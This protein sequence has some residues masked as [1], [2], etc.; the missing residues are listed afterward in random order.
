MHYIGTVGLSGS[1]GTDVVIDTESISGASVTKVLRITGDKAPNNY[2]IGDNIYL[3]DG[4]YV[5]EKIISEKFNVIDRM[6]DLGSDLLTY[7]EIIYNN[8]STVVINERDIKMIYYL[9]QGGYLVSV[10]EANDVF[11]KDL[12]TLKKMPGYLMLNSNTSSNN[13]LEFINNQKSFLINT[14]SNI[15]T[16]NNGL[17]SE[18]LEN[19]DYYRGN[20]CPEYINYVCSFWLKL[21]DPVNNCNVKLSIVSKD[22][23]AAE[24]GESSFDGSAINCWQEVRIPIKISYRA[25]KFAKLEFLENDENKNI[26]IA[27]MRIYYSSTYKTM[28]TDGSKWGYLDDVSKIRY[29]PVTNPNEYRHISL[30]ENTFITE[31]DLQM[32]YMAKFKLSGNTNTNDDFPL[33]YNDGTE[34]IIVKSA[35]LYIDDN[36]IFPIVFN[37]DSYSS[38]FDKNNTRAQYY[39]ETLSPDGDVYIY[40]IPHFIKNYIMNGKTY[41]VMAVITEANRYIKTASSHKESFKLKCIDTKGKVILEQDEYG[42]Q[43][44]YNYDENGVLSEKK[45]TNANDSSDYI[46][47][48][49]STTDEKVTSSDGIITEENYFDGEKITK[50]DYK[51]VDD[52]SSNKLV[53]EFGYDLFNGKVKKVSNNIGG[54]NFLYYDQAGRIIEM[55][56]K[57]DSEY[58]KYSFKINYDKFGDPTKFFYSYGSSKTAVDN[59]LIEK[60]IDRYSGSVTT[61]FYRTEDDIDEVKT[62]VDKYG[63]IIEDTV[64][65]NTVEYTRQNIEAS[66]GAANVTKIEDKIEGKTYNFSY[67]DF[68]NLKS[69]GF[70][71]E[72]QSELNIY[73]TSNTSTYIEENF[74]SDNIYNSLSI[75]DVALDDEKLMNGRIKKTNH[76]MYYGGQGDPIDYTY[77]S[78]GRIKQKTISIY[79]GFVSAPGTKI[80]E[81]KTFKNKTGQLIGKNVSLDNT[82]IKDTTMNFS[83]GYD[84]RGNIASKETYVKCKEDERNYKQ[85]FEYNLANQLVKEINENTGIEYNYSYN[86]D[87]SLSSIT[88]NGIVRNYNYDSTGRLATI[89]EHETRLGLSYDNLGNVLSFGAN[90]Y[91]WTRG[92]LLESFTNNSL[93]TNYYYNGFGKKYKKILSDNTIITYNYDNEKL[94]SENWSNGKKLRFMYDLEGISGIY[95][96]NNGSGSLYYY[97]KDEQ[98]SVV[99]ILDNDVEIVHYEYD[100]FGN[101]YIAYSSNDIIANLNPIRWKGM[102]CETENN[103]YFINNNTYCP[104][105]RQNLS[106]NV[107]EEVLNNSITINGLYPYQLNYK[108]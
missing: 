65:G 34:H 92:N 87:G 38:Y 61:K 13:N 105:L 11:N 60:I 58:N 46:V 63:R 5:G 84:Q 93:T 95:I 8:N 49:K 26:Q 16:I 59:L 42:V 64:Q 55:S 29:V 76:Q 100:S 21:L 81:T 66:Y 19:M 54:H 91:T 77:D 48:N 75:V 30:D 22:N 71:T 7:N 89:R 45:I 3:G 52:S 28:L 1:A 9:N 17:M 31:K 88:T 6:Y 82:I 41:D 15:S 35:W 103:L 94:L 90:N 102:Y 83:F 50:I 104:S 99:S 80:T 67:D 56:P 69:Y 47:Y 2:N 32:T 98:G 57:E 40:V 107:I 51:G 10:L 14:A 20:V 96:E 101:C 106:M 24:V 72:D 12:R 85:V 4:K 27:D 43:I 53:K 62:V 108:N 70:V 44:I 79:E 78:L 37:N 73:K 36:N 18:K 25:V 74:S 68:N 86:N 33:Y 23:E 39:T 97:V